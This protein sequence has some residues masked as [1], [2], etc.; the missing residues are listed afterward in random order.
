MSIPKVVYINESKFRDAMVQLRQ[1]GG[2]HQRAFDK[3][4]SLITGLTYGVEE[5]NKLTN[6]G[7]SRIQHCRKYDISNDA[8]RLVTLHTDG[9]IY[10]LH[11]GTH[12][13][14]DRWLEQN[15]GLTITVHKETKRVE[16]THVTRPEEGG[17]RRSAGPNFAASTAENVPFLKR[18]EGFDV[19]EVVK[20]NF[21]VKQLEGIDENTS[22]DDIVEI[23]S[24]IAETEPAVG[25]MLFDVLWELRSGN[26]YRALA[27]I[28]HF[29]GKA[30]DIADDPDL[31]KSALDSDVN[32]DSLLIISELDDEEVKKLFAPERFHEWML[33]PHKEQRRI[34]EKD[35]EKPIGDHPPRARWPAY[36]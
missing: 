16:V 23:T 26:N 21:L 3:A 15:K 30:T 36:V 7:E 19:R 18:L 34:A 9:Y 33:F 2:A 5:L 24:L 6:H 35:C 17:A 8:H 4:C 25:N 13:E 27:R 31:E 12:E 14:V 29:R 10:L 32:S 1:R 22:D 20:Q 11:V 28:E